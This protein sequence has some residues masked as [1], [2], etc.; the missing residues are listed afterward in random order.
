MLELLDG[1]GA[2]LYGLL[3]KLTLREDVADD[4]MQDLVIKLADSDGFA[5]ADSRLAYALT[6]A[7]NLAYT[8]RRTIRTTTV[9]DATANIAAQQMAALDRLVHAER[10][11][12]LLDAVAELPETMRQVVTLR[13]LE[14]WPHTR[15]AEHLGR[16]AA[17]VRM[18]RH[19][20]I[21]RLRETL[22]ASER[23][24]NHARP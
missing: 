3:L 12:A 4:L 23:E 18:I 7:A 13:Y 20:A 16:S 9:G 24:V 1:H 21:R 10:L 5:I 6:T 22:E 14:Q 11:E 8:W 2:R 19:R 17:A 15:I